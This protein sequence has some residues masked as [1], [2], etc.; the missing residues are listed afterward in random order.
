M[1]IH[2]VLLHEIIF[3][4]ILTEIGRKEFSDPD[5]WKID[6][7]EKNLFLQS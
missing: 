4:L 6:L 3:G 1:Y 5:F 2:R 7:F